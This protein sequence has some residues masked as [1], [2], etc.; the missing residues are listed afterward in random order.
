MGTK[1]LII[2]TGAQ[3]S[4]SLL[5]CSEGCQCL[6]W[7]QLFCSRQGGGWLPWYSSMQ[8]CSV[9]LPC[10]LC[11]REPC[12]IPTCCVSQNTALS[13]LALS[14]LCCSPLTACISS[15]QSQWGKTK[16]T[17]EDSSYI[18]IKGLWHKVAF[19]A[20]WLTLLLQSVM[21]LLILD[22]RKQFVPS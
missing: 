21:V 16:D 2:T 19:W 5:M 6:R 17:W 20:C 11:C 22:H 15:K 3:Q 7:R 9:A 8:R 10:V 12:P 4:F 14:F 18:G 1:V 13:V